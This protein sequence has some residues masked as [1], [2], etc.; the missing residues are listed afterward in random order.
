[1]CDR[2]GFH[3][4][5]RHFLH[6]RPQDGVVYATIRITSAISDNGSVLITLKQG[7][8][9]LTDPGGRIF[10]LWDD[11][12]ARE[13]FDTLGFKVCDVST[14]VSRTESGDTWISYVLDKTPVK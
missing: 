14:S 10:Y 6:E 9:D 13:L 5:V 3:K 7:S 11:L 1:M 2:L 12:K 8:G 4:S